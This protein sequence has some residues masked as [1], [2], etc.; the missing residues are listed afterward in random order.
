VR[1]RRPHAHEHGPGCH[2]HHG[3]HEHCEHHEAHGGFGSFLRGLLAGLPWSERADAEEVLALAAPPGGVVRIQSANGRIRIVGEER[4]DLEIRAQ[5]VARAE[6][7]EAAADLLRETR[8][9]HGIVAGAIEIEVDLPRRWNRRGHVHLEARVPRGTSVEVSASNGKVCIENLRGAVRARSSNGSIDVAGVVGD[10]EVSASNAKV[11]CSC[12]QGH[13]VARSSNGKIELAEHRGSV[14]ASTSNGLICASLDEVG[15]QGVQLATS[16]GR[17]ALELPEKVDA[18][19][20][21]RVDNGVIRCDRDLGK[22]AGERAGR[23]RGRLGQG[24]TPIRVRTSNGSVSL[25]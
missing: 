16:N 3:H 23:L 5:K 14:D 7:H 18:D 1:R 21:I 24:G 6:S 12:T 17:V 9:L 4:A 8:V 25:R 11:C 13:L 10:I 20:D 22:S 2:G 15:R 19:V